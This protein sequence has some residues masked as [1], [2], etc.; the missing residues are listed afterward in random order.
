MGARLPLRYGAD[1][2]LAAAILDAV[3]HDRSLDLEATAAR[4][5]LDRVIAP[6]ARPVVLQML[7][8]LTD[9]HYLVSHATGVRSFAFELVR[10]GWI[11]TGR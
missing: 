8:T 5:N 6:V 9:D 1:G 7:T 11:A 2:P 10:R 4:L 3:A